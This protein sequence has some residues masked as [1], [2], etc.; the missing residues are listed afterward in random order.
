MKKLKSILTLVT[1]SVLL[2]ACGGGSD[3]IYLQD[4]LGYSLA[5]RSW[6]LDDGVSIYAENDFAERYPLTEVY[7][8]HSDGVF[9]LDTV[10]KFDR[11]RVVDSISGYWSAG[12]DFITF[13]AL[14]DINN[15][16]AVVNG[17]EFVM[18]Y[19]ENDFDRF[20]ACDY[21]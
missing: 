21:F 18:I 13:R 10:S 5:G 20:Y 11:S 4:D 9:Y 6:C 7:T 3:R 14:G 15:V 19:S 2:S 16:D 1:F 12:Q 8:F 17:S